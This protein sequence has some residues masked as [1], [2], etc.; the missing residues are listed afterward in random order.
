MD[1]AH[2]ME[3]VTQVASRELQRYMASD[4]SRCAEPTSFGTMG[5]LR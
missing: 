1:R 3:G 4:L 2:L 5:R